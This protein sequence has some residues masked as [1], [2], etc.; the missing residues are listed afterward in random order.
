MQEDLTHVLNEV[1]DPELG[2][3][4]VDLGLIYV[5]EWNAEGIDV[6]FTTT[7][8]SCPFSGAL[9]QQISDILRHHFREAA[10]VR[11]RFILDP[12]WTPKRLS[13]NARKKLG[14]ARIAT[15]SSRLQRL[16]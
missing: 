12:P 10:S 3:G 15:A 6:A 9:L 16:L 13:E 4:I 14:W 5:A 7:S 11:V 2:I 1:E 8:P